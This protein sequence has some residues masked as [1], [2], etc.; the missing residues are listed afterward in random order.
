MKRH[1]VVFWCFWDKVYKDHIIC[2]GCLALLLSFA[3]IPLPV[4]CLFCLPSFCF[5]LNV[6]RPQPVWRCCHN[7]HTRR[8]GEI[9]RSKGSTAIEFCCDEKLSTM[10]YLGSCRVWVPFFFLG[11]QKGTSP[12]SAQSVQCAR[13]IQRRAL[14]LSGR[15]APYRDSR[16]VRSASVPKDVPGRPTP[17]E[18]C[19]AV[20]K[21]TQK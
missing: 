6:D 17:W 13:P 10:A 19:R 9:K 1:N 5:D 7:I 20:V 16:S 2:C 4:F 3:N 11:G 14:C 15:W 12:L 8:I 18:G 21:T